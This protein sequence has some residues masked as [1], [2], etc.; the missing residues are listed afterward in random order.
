MPVGI[1]NPV[2]TRAHSACPPHHVSCHLGRGQYGVVLAG[3]S[4]A[5]GSGGN[6]LARWLRGSP[7][8]YRLS[9]WG[10]ARLGSRQSL[11]TVV[12][13]ALVQVGLLPGWWAAVVVSRE[14]AVTGLRV[15]AAEKGV[16][17]PAGR[18][19][20]LKAAVTFIALL[21]LILW[22]SLVSDILLWLAL[23]LTVYSGAEYMYNG[24][25]KIRDVS[26]AR[27]Q[28]SKTQTK[29]KELHVK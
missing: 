10:I 5:R 26:S 20:K 27:P 13:I 8:R 25:R 11:V 2:D 9:G 6:G 7:Q 24:I 19:G 1:A 21:V 3:S 4:I 23:I 16:S 14:M 18:A 15:Q 29:Q 12:L 22:Q 28:D 17:I